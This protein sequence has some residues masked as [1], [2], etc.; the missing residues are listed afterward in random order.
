MVFKG[1]KNS[2]VEDRSRELF[3]VNPNRIAWIDVAKGITI[4]LVIIGHTLTFGSA[5]RNF[6][7]SFHMPLFFILSGYTFNVAEDFPAFFKRVKKLIKH[8]IYPALFVSGVNIFVQWMMQDQHTLSALWSLTKRMGDALWWASGVDVYAHPALGALWFLFSLFWA[9]VFMDAIYLVFPGKKTGYIYV[10]IGLL[11]MAIGLKG[12][13]LPQ[14]MDVTFMAMLFIYIGM[15]W[16]NY[17]NWLEHHEKLCFMSSIIIWVFCLNIPMYI[18]MATRSYPWTVCSTVE[19][20]CGSYA[21]C[22]LCKAFIANARICYV[23]QFIGMHTLLIFLVHHL[24]WITFPIRQSLSVGTASC[25]RV[26]VVLFTS[27]I[28]Y[29]IGYYYHKKI[30]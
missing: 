13:W 14:N 6:I 1:I 20:V 8:L 27:F 15:L 30:I 25:L 29:I 10:S 17:Q 11:G 28:I 26:S 16:K 19:A 3:Y 4:L 24:D 12:K 21:V 5:T 22:C 7:F 2:L 9:K 23:F 18:T